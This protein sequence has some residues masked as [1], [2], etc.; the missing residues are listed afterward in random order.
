[1]AANNRIKGKDKDGKGKSDK[2]KS[3]KGKSDKGNNDKG[4]GKGKDWKKTC[5]QYKSY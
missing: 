3:N 5:N 1:M 4:Y 2:G